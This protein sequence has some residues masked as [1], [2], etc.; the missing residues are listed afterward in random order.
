MEQARL[1]LK[2]MWDVALIGL[3]HVTS[4]PMSNVATSDQ[5]ILDLRR[6]QDSSIPLV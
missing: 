5:P 6:V 2:R 3:L 1:L 4:K